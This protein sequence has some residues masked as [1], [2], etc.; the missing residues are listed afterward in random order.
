MRITN[1]RSIYYGSTKSAAILQCL[2]NYIHPS[3]NITH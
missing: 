2:Q 3:N 1:W